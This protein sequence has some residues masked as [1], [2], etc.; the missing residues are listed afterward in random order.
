MLVAVAIMGVA[1]AGLTEVL[2]ING[3]FSIRLYNKMDNNSSASKF[4]ALIGKDIRSAYSIDPSSNST[5]L[6][7]YT[8]YIP[9][10]SSA[11][12]NGYPPAGAIDTIT[13]QIQNPTLGSPYSVI[14]TFVPAPSCTDGRSTTQTYVLVNLIGPLDGSTQPH[15][16]DYPA[17]PYN[18][19]VVVNLETQ[20]TSAGNASVGH[21]ASMG[22][23]AQ[24]YLRNIPNFGGQW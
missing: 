20:A 3:N 4:L 1:V 7:L 24:Y 2:W 23:R 10:T 16:F 14:R 19:S 17:N 22:M 11:C 8:M 13:Y 15:M 12:P 6:M 9:T 21:F 18:S 5:T